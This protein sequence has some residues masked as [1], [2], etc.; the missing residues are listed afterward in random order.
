MTRPYVDDASIDALAR[1][2]GIA[3]PP[4]RRAAVAERL[5]EMHA[6]AAEFESLPYFDF[7]PAGTFNVEWPVDAPE[8]NLLT[9]PAGG[10][11]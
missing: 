8:G 2:A 6:M 5:N 9:R 11:S 1:A 10:V 4:E 3:I 7:S